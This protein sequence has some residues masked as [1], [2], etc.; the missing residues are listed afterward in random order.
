MNGWESGLS[1]RQNGAEHNHGMMTWPYWT[2]TGLLINYCML[3]QL[4]DADKSGGLDMSEFCIAI[5][6]LVRMAE[7]SIAKRIIMGRLI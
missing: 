3:W 5:K 6:K 2:V 1:G 4:L 7:S